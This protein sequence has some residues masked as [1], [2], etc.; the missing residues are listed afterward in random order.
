MAPYRLPNGILLTQL[1]QSSEVILILISEVVIPFIDLHLFCFVFQL[2]W[3]HGEP[4]LTFLVFKV[5][6]PAL[7]LVRGVTKGRGAQGLSASGT[8][9]LNLNAKP[10]RTR[11]HGHHRKEGA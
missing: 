11:M 7:D 10:P 2:D 5:E 8:E 1:L 4:D 9:R 6:N 3:L